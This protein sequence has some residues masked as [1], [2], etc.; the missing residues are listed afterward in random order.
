MATCEVAI[1]AFALFC[2]VDR[3]EVEH[4]VLVV[5]LSADL[6]RRTEFLRKNRG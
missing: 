4:A 2:L 6:S 3:D 1:G 5:K